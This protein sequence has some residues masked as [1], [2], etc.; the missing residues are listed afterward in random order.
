MAS[1]SASGVSGIVSK[2]EMLGLRER[3]EVGVDGIEEAEEWER[4]YASSFGKDSLNFMAESAGEC[5]LEV[6]ALDPAEV[7]WYRGDAGRRLRKGKEL[8]WNN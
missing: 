7:T 1:A 4:V 8:P 6:G 2:L 5:G 3:M